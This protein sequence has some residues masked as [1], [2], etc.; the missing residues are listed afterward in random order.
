[1]NVKSPFRLSHLALLFLAIGFLAACVSSSDLPAL[2]TT[3]YLR[4][5]AE[6]DLD[7]MVQASCGAW[8]PQARMELDAFAGVETRLEGLACTV[9]SRIG[10][11]A[12]VTCSGAILAAYGA[13]DRSFPLDGRTFQLQQQGGLWLVC[14]SE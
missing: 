4:A 14:G 6:K 3:A 5:L 9:A 12:S 13:E 8:E 2:V 1:M 11:S 10:T 7:R